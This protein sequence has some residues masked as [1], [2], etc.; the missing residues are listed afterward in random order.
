MPIYTDWAHKESG[1]KFD[2]AAERI[3]RKAVKYYDELVASQ[4]MLDS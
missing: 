3:L 2:E 1:P 4:T